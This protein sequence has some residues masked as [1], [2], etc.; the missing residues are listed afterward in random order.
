MGVEAMYGEQ[1]WAR[2]RAAVPARHRTTFRLICDPSLVGIVLTGGAAA[3][4]RC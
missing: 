1:V 4:E 2:H 3:P